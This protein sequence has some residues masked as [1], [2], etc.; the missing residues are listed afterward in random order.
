[1]DRAGHERKGFGT[2]R[3]WVTHSIFTGSALGIVLGILVAF[4]FEYVNLPFSF[5]VFA[6]QG[7]FS[8]LSH[9]FL[10]SITE[11]GIFIFTKR[12][13]LAH[14]H[15]DNPF[16]NTG[17]SLLGIFLFVLSLHPQLTFFPP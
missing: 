11:G 12:F 9:L 16:L 6:L 14:F 10:D 2:Q 17:F 3:T 4:G 5:V 13:A 8:A 1:M 15:Y 7:F